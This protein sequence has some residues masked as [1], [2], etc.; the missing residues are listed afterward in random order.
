MQHDGTGISIG[1]GTERGIVVAAGSRENEIAK[2]A[3]DGSG[4]IA[5]ITTENVDEGESQAVCLEGVVPLGL[6]GAACG[7]FD[8]LVPMANSTGK[9]RPLPTA[10]GTYTVVARALQAGS[11]EQYV[12]MLVVPPR[13]VTVV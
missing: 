1:S 4:K 7:Q 2:L 13:V 9:L 5:G 10:P 3:T 6:L 12:S 11:A 8:D